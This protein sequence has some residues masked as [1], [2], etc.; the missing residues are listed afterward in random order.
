MTERL[1]CLG[2][3]NTYGYDPR[4][5]FGGRYPAGQRWTG[6]LRRADREVLNLGIN[7]LTVPRDPDGGQLTGLL[8]QRLP[9]DAVTVML[10]SNDLLRGDG[11]ES[12][13]E[14]MERLL[15]R[16]RETAGETRLLLIAPPPLALGAWVPDESLIEESRRLAAAYRR[17]A[18]RRRI[19]FAD[20]GRWGV[21]LCFDGVHFSAAGH[22]AFARNLERLLDAPCAG[23]DREA[24]DDPQ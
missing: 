23:P 10:G 14:R 8:R 7:G 6:L 18:E 9:A 22:A 17:L 3:S 11:A 4:S 24:E 20:A 15:L 2:D 13:A 21:E 5:P 19:P 12:T 16:L 1:I